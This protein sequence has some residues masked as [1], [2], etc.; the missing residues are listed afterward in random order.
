MIDLKNPYNWV[1]ILV[2]MLVGGFV[3]RQIGQR[4][5]VVGQVSRAAGQAA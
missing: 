2:V 3:L 4:V 1:A 5:P